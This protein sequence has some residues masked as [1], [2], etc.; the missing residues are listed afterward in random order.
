MGSPMDAVATRLRERGHIAT[1]CFHPSTAVAIH[2]ATIRIRHEDF[3][4]ERLEML[5]DPLALGGRLDQ[6]ARAR[7]THKQGGQSIARR[8]NAA[9][10]YLATLGDDPD[11]AVL[12]MQVNGTILHGWSPLCCASERVFAGG[13]KRY[14]RTKEASRFILSLSPS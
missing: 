6:E 1:V 11:L 8:R 2:Q 7:A 13:A 9:I 3:M 10:D 4:A 5:R 14:H 12:L